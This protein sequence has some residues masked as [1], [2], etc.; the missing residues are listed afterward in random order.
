MECPDDLE[1]FKAELAS[2]IAKMN[3][4]VEVQ[5]VACGSVI[6]TLIGDAQEVQ[7]VS[8]Y[9]EE[10]GLE[11]PSYGVVG[12]VDIV[13][14]EKE[15]SSN[16]LPAGVI[17]VIVFAILVLI[18]GAIWFFNKH[19]NNKKQQKEAEIQR[20][21]WSEAQATSQTK[22][23]KGPKDVESPTAETIIELKTP[24]EQNGGSKVQEK[25]KLNKQDP[26]LKWSPTSKP[27]ETPVQTLTQSLNTDGR[28]EEPD[29][30]QVTTI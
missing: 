16:G 6:I 25:L 11:L 21:I 22:D 9:I 18:V 23:K 24:R 30:Q 15:S 2:E 26:V 8:D 28:L 3:E 20:A 10:T 14:K 12:G 1:A 19:Q 4:N 7:S 5:G 29:A 27:L 13:V 17:V